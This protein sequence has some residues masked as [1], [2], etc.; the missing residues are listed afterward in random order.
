MNMGGRERIKT[1]KH[2]YDLMNMKGRA[3]GKKVEEGARHR[4]KKK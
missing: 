2:K 3:E 1:R 4:N